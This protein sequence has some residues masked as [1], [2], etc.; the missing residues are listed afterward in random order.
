MS[1]SHGK[2]HV[3]FSGVSGSGVAGLGEQVFLEG[4]AASP[5]SQTLPLTF[6]HSG[7][8][9][10]QAWTCFDTSP[11]EPHFAEG[12]T[13]KRT[14]RAWVQELPMLRREEAVG[15]VERGQGDCKLIP[16]HKRVA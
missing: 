5:W 15:V 10:S 4:N 14:G 11:R 12:G 9:M 8:L 13:P 6:L 3:G 7:N 2:E 1:A 16:G